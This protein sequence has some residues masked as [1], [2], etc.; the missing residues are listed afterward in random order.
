MALQKTYMT[1]KGPA[2]YWIAG[3]I[4]IDNYSKTAYGRLYGFVSKEHCDKPGSVP[5]VML[6]YKIDPDI[7]DYYFKK[8]I[9]VLVDVTP[10]SQFYR[11][12][13]DVNIRDGAN[14]IINFND[15]TEVY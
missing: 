4:Q 8:E 13:K 7:Y 12:V 5:V 14:E 6:D 1:P 15:A 10:Q 2:S 9:M 11:Y 3:L